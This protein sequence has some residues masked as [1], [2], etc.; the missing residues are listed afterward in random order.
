MV[1]PFD[2]AYLVTPSLFGPLEWLFF[3]LQIAGVGAGV[4]LLVVRKDSNA[5]RKRLLDRLGAILAG[6]GGLGVVLGLLRLGLVGEFAKPYW[7]VALL[8]AE[9]GLAGYVAYYVRFIYPR[10]LAQS[11]TSRGK[12]S[13]RQPPARAQANPTQAASRG[14]NGALHDAHDAA[15]V[16]GSAGRGGRREARQRRKRKR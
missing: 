8:L 7:F 1:N 6:V 16:D 14:T 11:P 4:Y 13:T 2:P 10:Q 9:L 15:E 5:L 12:S 3:L